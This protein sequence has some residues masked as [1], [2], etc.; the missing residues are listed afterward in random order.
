MK[1]KERTKKQKEYLSTKICK[2]DPDECGRPWSHL[3][4]CNIHNCAHL[5]YKWFASLSNENKK[6]ILENPNCYYHIKDKQPK[7]KSVKTKLNTEE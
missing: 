3:C 1:R 2:N 7:N 6:Y 5:K 4:D